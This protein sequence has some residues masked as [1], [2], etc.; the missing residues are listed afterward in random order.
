MS[1]NM[2][3]RV[4][5]ALP[6]YEIGDVIGR[7]GCGV[8]LGGIHLQLQRKVAIKQIP[9]ESAEDLDARR[10]F[11]AE[12]RIMASINHPHVVPV[13]DYVEND[14]V[15]LLVMEYLPAGTVLSRFSSQGF[16]AASAVAVSLA[17]ASALEAAHSKGVL[18]RDVKPAN[19]MFDE[20]GTVKLTDF[21]IAKNFG[22]EGGL[23]TQ[24]G[25]VLGT[26]CYISPEQVRGHPVS[27][28]TDIYALSTM[29]YQLLSGVLPFPPCE[30]PVAT[31]FMH[32]SDQ[33]IPLTKAKP[34]IPTPIAD[35][36]MRGLATE[37]KDR[38]SSAEA[39]GV[40]L[41]AAAT[42]CWG[43]NWLAQAGIPVVGNESITA[44]S[45][46]ISSPPML[47]PI[48]WSPPPATPPEARTTGGTVL[49]GELA[50]PK[51]PL[52]ATAVLALV[53]IALAIIG[54][55]APQRGGDLKPGMVTIAGV[56]PVTSD[57]VQIDMTK[58]IPVTV[59]GIPG[60]NASL[61]LNVLGFELGNH[62]A[63]LAGSG[64]P[65]STAELPDPLHPLIVAGRMSGE[66]RISDGATTT[67]T[68]HLG[69][70][71]TQSAT[72]TG[73]AAGVVFLALFALAYLESYARTLRRGRNK[74]SA[75]V[76]LP[77]AAALL[78]VSIVG[79][80]WVLMGREPTVA[81]LFGCAAVGAAAGVGGVIAATRQGRVN[82]YRRA[83]RTPTTGATTVYT[84]GKTVIIREANTSGNNTGGPT[85]GGSTTR[86]GGQPDSG[87]TRV[88]GSG[89]QSRH[90]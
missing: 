15:C 49:N 37:P 14:D 85:T 78:A 68:Y 71:S 45:A 17:C 46:A 67:A 72:T 39:F 53:T 12:A 83:H 30:D 69:I 29:L 36:V 52:I 47:S 66:L 74:V 38:W 3:D 54:L 6:G 77:L 82:R 31:L 10:R 9:A 63:P 90:G 51:V 32:A 41:A 48:P 58:P 55:G 61:S 81:T 24:T 28:A 1:S 11:I 84:S 34:D 44:A 5:A 88:P 57:E 86:G 70:R 87:R 7:G 25:M 60:D 27:P 13:Y 22:S 73:V 42:H 26:W 80:V 76:G 2:V 75:T 4:R 20:N 56:D 59:T 43:P 79:A 21:G 50:S 62:D 23:Q 89:T 16:D 65:N 33:P 64:G 35:V 40:A 18:H 19:L 8:V